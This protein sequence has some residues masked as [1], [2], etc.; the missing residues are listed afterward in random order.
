[1][2]ASNY[3]MCVYV[4][5]F[6]MKKIHLHHKLLVSFFLDNVLGI[7]HS[8]CEAVRLSLKL[9]TIGEWHPP[10]H[11]NIMVLRM[12]GGGTCACMDTTLVLW[13]CIIIY[14]GLTS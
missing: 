7:P 14:S 13:S 12:G 2:I 1:M 3:I 8:N 5:S 11:I 6:Q 4:G 10:I 9:Q